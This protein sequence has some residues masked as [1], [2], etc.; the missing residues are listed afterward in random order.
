ME[1]PVLV[2]KKNNAN[3][4][5][6]R[7]VAS[8]FENDTDKYSSKL[9]LECS[10][11]NCAVRAVLADKSPINGKMT[12]FGVADPQLCT[13]AESPIEADIKVVLP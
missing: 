1:C 10:L 12:T 9:E 5:Y 6:L 8:S 11:A 2:Q 7:V 13:Q 4:A 3:E